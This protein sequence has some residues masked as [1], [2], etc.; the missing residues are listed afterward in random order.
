VSAPGWG[1]YGETIAKLC[2][3]RKQNFVPSAE[4]GYIDQYFANLAAEQMLAPDAR[5]TTRSDCALAI[6][7]RR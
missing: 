2:T 1:R 7:E 3:S 6:D 5:S 4:K